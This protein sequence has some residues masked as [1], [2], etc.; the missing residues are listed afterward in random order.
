MHP[1]DRPRSSLDLLLV[2]FLEQPL[3]VGQALFEIER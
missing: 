3:Q 2:V 1:A